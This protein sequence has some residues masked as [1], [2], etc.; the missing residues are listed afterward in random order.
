[1]STEIPNNEMKFTISVT[2]DYL[3]Q[4]K[5]CCKPGISFSLSSEMES[6]I[7]VA[8]DCIREM[9][10]CCELS[11]N[12]ARLKSYEREGNL[13]KIM[14]ILTPYESEEEFRD[15]LEMAITE[16]GHRIEKFMNYVKR[17]EV[18]LATN[19][20]K[21]SQC[22]GIGN[23]SKW[24]YIRERGSPTQRVLRSIICSNCEGKGHVAMTTEEQSHLSLF[25][26]KANKLLASLRSLQN[27]VHIHT[28]SRTMS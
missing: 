8:Q 25:L 5:H 13:T 21:C 22:E 11:Q 12:A 16:L 17:I 2:Q 26:K 3:K 27:S 23:L 18:I 20:Y 1:M 4:M 10:Y 19:T 15:T 9:S 6:T 14:L 28:P 24:I 7:A